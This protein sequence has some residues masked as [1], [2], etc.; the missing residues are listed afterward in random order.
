LLLPM[1]DYRWSTNSPISSSPEPVPE[2]PCGGPIC[3]PRCKP[4]PWHVKL[5]FFLIPSSDLV[6]RR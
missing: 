5:S 1:S 2:S 4:K 6:A 3:L